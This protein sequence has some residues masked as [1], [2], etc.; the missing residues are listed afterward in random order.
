MPPLSVLHRG[1]TLAPCPWASWF[2]NWSV[3]VEML[4]FSMVLTT[5]VLLV[6]STLVALHLVGF[7]VTMVLL[8]TGQI[9]DV[10]GYGSTYVQQDK[11]TIKVIRAKQ[12]RDAGSFVC[13][14]V[15][16]FP[17][18]TYILPSTA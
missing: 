14:V 10:H 18:E 2:G 4:N 3:S 6:S 17:S 16:G 11:K 7:D 12:N 8:V 13:V 5:L 15:Q 1:L 9:M